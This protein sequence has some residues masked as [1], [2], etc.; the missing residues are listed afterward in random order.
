M[1]QPTNHLLQIVERIRSEKRELRT[2]QRRGRVEIANEILRIV[3]SHGRKFFSLYG[4][5]SPKANQPDRISFFEL[6]LRD[7]LWFIDKCTQHPIYTAYKGRWRGFSEGGT[8][9]NLVEAL[10]D[11]IMRGEKIHVKAHFGPW[12]EWVSGGDLWGYGEKEMA[13]VRSEVE[14]LLAKNGNN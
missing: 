10:R 5:G 1:T 6:R 14:S 8:L 12:P 9:R 13:L 3:A 11:Y 2:A 7:R 4:D